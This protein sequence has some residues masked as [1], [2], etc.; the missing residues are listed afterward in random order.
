MA[1]I[2]HLRFGT[3]LHK[4]FF[5][6]LRSREEEWERRGF[7]PQFILPFTKEAIKEVLKEKLDQLG[8]KG[9]AN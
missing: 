2:T 9:K 6:G 3:D 7:N 5:N 1:G 4:A 8:S